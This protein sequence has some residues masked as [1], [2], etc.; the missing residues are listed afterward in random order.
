[1]N[2]SKACAQSLL[3][4]RRNCVADVFLI[5]YRHCAWVMEYKDLYSV[6][7]KIDSNLYSVKYIYYLCIQNEMKYGTVIFSTLI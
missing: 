6:K 2:V 5:V 7:Y 3:L 1:M 4:T